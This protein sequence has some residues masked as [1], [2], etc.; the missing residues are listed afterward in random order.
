MV[1]HHAR[2]LHAAGGNRSATQRRR[3]ISVRYAG[4]D[5]RTRLAPARHSRPTSAPWPTA[6]PSPSPS[7]PSR[8][9]EPSAPG[10]ALATGSSTLAGVSDLGFPVFDADNHYYE[11]LDAFTRHLDPRLGGRCVQWCQIGN[12][13]YHVVAGRVSHA[14]VNPTFDPIAKAGAMHRLL[15][16]Q[17]GGPVPA[18]VPQGARADPRR[19]PRPRRACRHPRRPGARG[20]V[21]LPDARNALRGASEGRPWRL[22]IWPNDLAKLSS[23]TKPM[24]W[25]A[26]AA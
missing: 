1:V 26:T 5:V 6:T 16:R 7:I 23:T 9:S 13:S 2:T 24:C 17:S 15:P 22:G 21:D 4:D 11:A 25:Q 19:V 14:V 12:R 8:H 18:R 3:A 20:R 10:P